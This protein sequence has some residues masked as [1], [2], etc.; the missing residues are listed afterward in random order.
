MYSVEV[1]ESTDSHASVYQNWTIED[2]KELT[3]TLVEHKF[4]YWRAEAREAVNF[5]QKSTRPIEDHNKKVSMTML[6]IA[7][8][9]IV[10][11]H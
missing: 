9:A 4:Q 5:H 2:L 8:Q 11:E 1:W 3:V 6:V 7:K 10:E